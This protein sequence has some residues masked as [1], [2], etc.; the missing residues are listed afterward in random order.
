MLRII[1]PQSP[2][3][4]CAPS[5]AGAFSVPF[6]PSL[7][8]FLATLTRRFFKSGRVSVCVAEVVC[9]SRCNRDTLPRS[10]TRSRPASTLLPAKPVLQENVGCCVLRQKGS[11]TRIISAHDATQAHEE[12]EV[13]QNAGFLG[14]WFAG[15]PAFWILVFLFSGFQRT[16]FRLKLCTISLASPSF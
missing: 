4:H 1:S 11:S 16:F 6:V 14:C 15:F 2:L 9:H 13:N 12:N 5:A 3:P 7:M 8:V 10:V